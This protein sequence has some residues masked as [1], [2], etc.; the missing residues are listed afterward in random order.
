M[1][2][3]E[4]VCRDLV[5]RWVARANE[6]LDAALHLLREGGRFRGV[7]AFH[8]QQAVEKYMKALLVRHQ[9]ARLTGEI[10]PEIHAPLLR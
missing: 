5:L 2:P 3:P 9:V 10:S 1:S 7:I 4:E 8:C 6:D